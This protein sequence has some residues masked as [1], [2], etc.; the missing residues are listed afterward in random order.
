MTPVPVLGWDTPRHT[1]LA[2]R[3]Q[4]LGAS[5]VA[6][7]LGLSHWE[8]PWEIWASKTGRL[9][10]PDLSPSAAAQLG[11]DL[12][13]WLLAQA[14]KLI[15]M[16][17]DRTPHMLYAHAAHGWRLCSPDAFAADGG[18]VEAK[19]AALLSVWTRIDD[20]LDGGVP[21]GYELQC[22]WQMHIMDRPRVY[23]VAL[24]AGLGLVFRVVE[25]D[26]VIEAELVSQASEWWQHHVIEGNEPAVG[27]ADVEVI[28]RV[29]VNPDPAATLDLGATDALEW[30]RAYRAALEQESAAKSVKKEYGA[31]LKALLGDRCTG[32]WDGRKI[33]TWNPVKGDV[34][35][36][37]MARDL[38]E[39][40]G[41]DLPDPETYRSSGGRTLSVK[42]VA[43]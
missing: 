28:Q 6:A 13:P 19:T 42:K 12:E 34:D 21:L 41:V 36:E 10:T 17:V 26:L 16:P 40:N 15:G 7:A 37:R 24:V 11:T 38:A 1:W 43:S 32:I 20:W 33:V 25:R 2:E 22:R 8:T 39:Q 23:L 9:V 5:D 35:W 3:R 29:Y 30:C 4:G 14:P 18:L 27:R 31:R